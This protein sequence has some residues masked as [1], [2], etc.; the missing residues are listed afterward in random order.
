LFGILGPRHWGSVY[1]LGEG[2]ESPKREIFSQV[3]S[4][5]HGHLPFTY[6]YN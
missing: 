2:V 5:R 4:G 6:Y 1:E 3:R